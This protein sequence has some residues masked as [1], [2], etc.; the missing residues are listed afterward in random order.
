MKTRVQQYILVVIR[1]IVI[2]VFILVLLGTTNLYK[3]SFSIS[4]DKS[5]IFEKLEGNYLLKKDVNQFILTSDNILLKNMPDD[6]SDVINLLVLGIRGEN[7][8]NGGL[9]TDTILL[10]SFNLQSRKSYI[11]IIPRDLFIYVPGLG[12]REKVNTVYNFGVINGGVKEGLA[13]SKHF[14]SRLLGVYIDHIA[15]VDFNMFLQIIDLVG[16]IDIVLENDFIEDKQWG[17]DVYGRNCEQFILPKGN[18]HLDGQTALKFVRSRFSSSDFDRQKRAVMV[19]VAAA[20][21]ARSLGLDDINKITQLY[22]TIGNHIKTDMGISNIIFYYNL[23]HDKINFDTIQTRT[24]LPDGISIIQTNVGGQYVL[25][26]IRDG[27]IKL[28]NS[29]FNE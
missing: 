18:N 14:F 24:L 28:R 15:V 20:D 1:V 17:C 10:F 4:S 8:G 16:G 7:D 19:A 26:P 6:N 12:K 29:L 13:F 3:R 5:I 21:K 22:M 9:L 23:L 11:T 27:F 2:A 25:L